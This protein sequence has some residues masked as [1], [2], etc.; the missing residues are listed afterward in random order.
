MPN[1]EEMER[2]RA[3]MEAVLH[4][5]ARLIIVKGEQGL[6]LTDDEGVSTRL[7]LDGSKEEVARGILRVIDER[8]ISAG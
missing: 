4:T 2:M 7:A 1:P 8:L 3:T 6:I 5:P